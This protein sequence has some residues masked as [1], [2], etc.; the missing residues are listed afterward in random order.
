M[1]NIYLPPSLKFTKNDILGII[2]QLPPP[3]VLC[4][5]FKSHNDIWWCDK[6]DATGRIIENIINDVDLTIL[7]KYYSHTHFSAYSGKFSSIDLTIISPSELKLYFEWNTYSDL[8]CSD[9]FPI[10]ISLIE[11]KIIGRRSKWVF[12]NVNWTQ[13]QNDVNFPELNNHS[14][15]IDD[16]NSFISNS[17]IQTANKNIHNTS[18][19][20][21][22]VPVPWWSE[23]INQAI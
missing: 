16:K 10:I 4:G 22:K 7:N 12:T 1:C 17:I 23:E 11:P 2:H 21:K 20:H 19:L 5:D 18:T 14:L 9:Q 8:C 15:S 6:T 3:C 13:F